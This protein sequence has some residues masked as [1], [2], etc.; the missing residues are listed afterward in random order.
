MHQSKTTLSEKIRKL[1]NDINYF[2]ETKVIDSNRVKNYEDAIKIAKSFRQEWALNNKIKPFEALIIFSAYN[3]TYHALCGIE[4]TLKIGIAC[5]D[6]PTSA[7]RVQPVFNTILELANELDFFNEEFS[8]GR[9][10]QTSIDS[11]KQKTE[12][13]YLAGR[14][15]KILPTLKEEIKQLGAKRLEE[16]SDKL[17][18]ST[19][20][21]VG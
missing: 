2:I 12:T 6:N 3:A 5:G 20:G 7:E 9:H 18:K 8:E 11:L 15:A 14:S 10:S 1:S 4:K 13:V 17:Y 19:A 16:V 21:V